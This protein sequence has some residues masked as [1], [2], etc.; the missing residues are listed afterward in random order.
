M[1]T[2]EDELKEVR[3]YIGIWITEVS[4]ANAQT[5][6]DINIISESLAQQLLNLIFGYELNDLNRLELNYPSI[7][8]GDTKDAKIAF[9]VTSS[10]SKSKIN[11]TIESFIKNNFDKK[12]INGIKF[13]VLGRR[14]KMS[15]LI[16]SEVNF[17]SKRDV[18][19]V[20]DIINE[21]ASLYYKDHATFQKI[22]SFL[23]YQFSGNITTNIGGNFTSRESVSTIR[24]EIIVLEIDKIKEEYYEKEFEWQTRKQVLKKLNRFLDHSNE[25]IAERIF[26]FIDDIYD[27]RGETEFRQKA[28]DIKDILF[29]FLP[30][31]LGNGNQMGIDNLKMCCHI[32]HDFAYDSFIYLND[33]RTATYGLWI[34]KQV[35]QLG[36][37][38]GIEVIVEFVHSEYEYLEMQ[39]Q[40]PERTDLLNAQKLAAI[41]RADLNTRG[42]CLPDMP[43][44][45]MILV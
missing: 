29:N 27:L 39:L 11:K 26:Y 16:V 9:Q 38:N 32:G 8:L 12:Y 36:K 25:H 13:F 5:F 41:F 2:V 17:N 6:F 28:S 40:R 44:E 21:I 7:D 23:A 24:S 45:L 31:A 37:K 15:H 34:M 22:K 10:I 20:E 3:R 1:P 30:L 33:L 14:K 19:F 4:L 42:M 18:L 35:Y 43:Q